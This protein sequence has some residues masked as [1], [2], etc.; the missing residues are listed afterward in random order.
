[1]SQ[2]SLSQEVK[3]EIT[4]LEDQISEERTFREEVQQQFDDLQKQ[5][6]QERTKR[7]EVQQK[8][9][10]LQK[11][12]SEERTFREEVQGKF[13]DLQNQVSEE[14]TKREEV[15]RQLNAMQNQYS[16]LKKI[17]TGLSATVQRLNTRSSSPGM[18]EPEPFV[19]EVAVGPIPIPDSRIIKELPAI[20]AEFRGKQ[21]QLLYQGFRDGFKPLDFHRH[22]DNHPNTLTLALDV[23][24]NIFGGFTPVEWE[25]RQDRARRPV[26]E[27]N[28]K[29]DESETSFLF[30]LKNPQD[31][32]PKR[33]PLR[34]EEKSGAIRCGA[35]EVAN[36]HDICISPIDT[37]NFGE[38]YE[39]PE[40]YSGIFKTEVDLKVKEIEVFQIID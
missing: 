18:I 37:A 8:F 27:P 9:S 1:L 40:E 13:N 31:L 30:T 19:S 28:Y 2:L 20:F 29:S 15:Q 16:E 26:G 35:G 10:D 39:V 7:E 4:R 12:A 6:S 21:F 25:S 3:K 22:C 17:A 23:E 36:F 5:V 24:G 38:H 33:F 14:R 34:P 32:P 11:Q